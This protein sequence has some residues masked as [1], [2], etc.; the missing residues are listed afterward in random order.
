MAKNQQL[1]DIF[2][3]VLVEV[4]SAHTTETTK[5]HG[6]A[7]THEKSKGSSHSENHSKSSKDTTKKKSDGHKPRM[8]RSVSEKHNSIDEEP[9]GIKDILIKSFVSKIFLF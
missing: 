6:S 5:S 8:K 9:K 2:C 7:T 1:I 3:F 4:R